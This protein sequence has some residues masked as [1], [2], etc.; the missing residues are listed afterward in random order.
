MGVTQ[1]SLMSLEVHICRHYLF[2]SSTRGEKC[3]LVMAKQTMN[4]KIMKRKKKTPLKVKADFGA[5]DLITLASDLGLKNQTFFFFRYLTFSSQ[6]SLDQNLLRIS[7]LVLSYFPVSRPLILSFRSRKNCQ[8]V[9]GKA[10]GTGKE[11]VIEK[12]KE[13]DRR[14]RYKLEPQ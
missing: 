14:H 13:K 10:V 3:V 11:V 8:P 2:S 1:L 12:V 6:N 4:N 7:A 5:N 9:F